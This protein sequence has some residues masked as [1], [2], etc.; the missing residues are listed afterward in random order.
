MLFIAFTLTFPDVAASTFVTMRLWL[1]EN[2]DWFFMASMNLVLLFCVV[3]AASPVGRIR[4]GGAEAEPMFSRLSWVCMLF[5]AGIGI[6]I[7]FY[8][9]LEPMN[10]ALTPPL[11]EQVQ[12]EALYRLAM[13]T[14]IYHW[15]F[16]PGLSM[17]WWDLR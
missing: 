3:I 15:A 12:G 14:T 6:G 17:L 9:V 2:L 5:A 1:T 7:M 13:A 11:N 16:H 4:I 10:H 8:G